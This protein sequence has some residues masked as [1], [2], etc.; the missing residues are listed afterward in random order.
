[1]TRNQTIAVR[2]GLVL[3]SLLLVLMLGLLVLTRT[4]WGREQVRGVVVSQLGNALD[5][6]VE[7][8]RLEGNLLVRWR[9]VDVTIT[10]PEGRPFISA[11]TVSTRFS[12]RGLLRRRIILR[13]PRV[14]R[15]LVVLDHPPGEK[16]NY[17]RILP[18]PEPDPT[19]PGWG[20]WIRL[21]DLVIIDSRVMVRSEWE[22]DPELSPAERERKIAEALSAES[23]ANIQRVPGGFQNIMDFR[24]VSARLS[25]V[26]LADPDADR[27]EFHVAAL[28]AVAQPF[29]PPVA[30]VRGLE[31]TF[32]L[33]ADSLWFEDVRA[34]LPDSRLIAS[35]VY[36]LETAALHLRMTGEPL[37]FNDMR[38]LYPRLPEEGGGPMRLAIQ[39]RQAATRIYAEDM[40]VRVGGGELAGDLR[41]VVGD[42]LRILPTDL[43]FQDLD[44]RPVDRMIPGVEFP[45]HGVLDGRLALR[46]VPAAMQVDGDVTL[47]HAPTGRSRVVAEG[48]VA[49][50][51]E[52]RFSNLS[53][54][55]SPL[56]TD[57]VR[58]EV[59][60]LPPGAALTGRAVLDGTFDGPLRLDADLALEDPAT[61]RSRV[62]ARGT[63][64]PEPGGVRFT[65]FDM[66]LRPLQAELVRPELPELPAGSTVTGRLR[67]D[68]ATYSI[69]NLQG[70]LA[71]SDPATGESRVAVA[72]GLDLREDLRF[73]ALDLTFQPLRA[74]LLRE[75]I[76]Q[77]PTGS[78][79]TGRLRLDGDPTGLLDLDGDLA[80]LDPATG[81]SRVALA[82]GLDLRDGLRLRG[83]DLTFQPLLTDLVREELP[84]LPPD[85]TV[86]G[87]L[88]LDGA[89]G[90]F[91]HVAGD[92]TLR[93][94]A[95]GTSRVAGAGGVDMAGPLTFHGLDLRF[96]PLQMALVRR[97]KPDLP[98]GGTLTGRAQLDGRPDA[99]LAVSGDLVH[100]EPGEV[101]RVAGHVE[102][103]PGGWASVDVQLMPL[104]LVVAGR[105][106]PDAGLRGAVRGNL[107]A[108]GDLGDLSL[109]AD[110]TVDDGG[111]IVAEGHLD[112]EADQPAYDL[113]TRVRGFDLAAVTTRAPATTDLTGD[114]VARGR[115]LDPATMRAELRA[116]LVGSAVEDLAAD[117]IHLRMEIVEGLA[118]VDSSI[119]HI[120][121]AVA[122]A[123]GEFG[124]V[125]WRDGELRYRVDLADLHAVAPVFPAADTGVVVPRAPVRRA[126]LAEARA[127]A[128]RAERRRLVEAI[129]TGRTPPPEAVPEPL[130]FDTLALAGIPRDTVSGSVE[131]E[132]V[133]R[134][135]VEVFDLV[136][137]AEVED[138]VLDG[139]YVGW[140][141]AEYA[142]IQRGVP[143]PTLELDAVAERLLVEGF[144][145]D[146][147]LAY[148]RHRGDR[149]GAGRA[150]LAAWQNDDTDYRADAEYTLALDR[151]EVRLHDLALRFDTI[152]WRTTQPG[153]VRWSGDGVEVESLELASDAGG[154]V[155]VDGRLP[156]DGEAELRVALHEV[157]LAH[158][159]LLLQD[160]RELAGR[161]SLDAEVTGT[162]RSPIFEGVGN[163]VGAKRNGQ[164]FPDA[165]LSFSYQSRELTFGAEFFEEE[166]RSFATA[167][168]V[169]PIDLA[170]VDPASPRLLDR[171]LAVDVRAD[172]LPLD[173]LGALT[174]EVSDTRGVVAGEFSIRGTWTDPVLEGAASVEE[175][176]FRVVGTGVG[177]RDVSGS[178]R[179][180]GSELVVDSLVA[181]SGG[182]VRLTGSLD[183]STLTEP[184]FDLQ[185][186]AENA[187]AMRTDDIQLRV[188]ADLEVTGPFD[189]VLVAGQARTR[190]SVIYIP[191]TRDKALVTLDDPELLDTLE[192]RLLAAAEELIET[193]SPLLGNLEVE[194]DLHIEPDTWV[195]S[196]DYNVEIYTPP[197]LPPLRV[198]LDQSL[199]RLTLEGTVNS[200]RGEYSFMG[201]RFRVTRGSATFVG[202]ADP[203][204]L[205]QVAAEHEVQLPGREAFSI[206]VVIGG[207]AL[208][209]TLTVESDARPPIAE[210]D[211]LTYIALGRAAGSVLQQQGSALSGR[212]TQSGDLV[213]N[214][215]GL[216][217]M[218]M[219]ALAAN[220][221]LDQFESEM[222]RELGLDVLHIAPADLPAELFSGRFTDLFRGTEVEAGRY[223]GPRLF[224]AVRTRLTTEARPGA[225]VEYTTPAGYRWTTS[226]DSRFLPPRPTLREVDPERVSVFGAF[227]FREWR[228]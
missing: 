175:A 99:R 18:D 127:A 29:R 16:W 164:E 149:Q 169:L 57:L 125:A 148:I 121:S 200:D 224:A 33:S 92:L 158:V 105:F 31:G 81:E 197:D 192:G 203:D 213:G 211:I 151:G 134:G 93:D 198:Q 185:V 216:A 188:D 13:D 70:D 181:H 32:L 162:A 119:V 14:V 54:T 73:R 27:T 167:E 2:V 205:L 220:T 193:P 163:V 36:D 114:I 143:T 177:Y 126:A 112:L 47:H 59:P 201:R 4:D 20:D 219:T 76:P 139:N 65:A 106:V 101:S 161:V 196:T 30:D 221:L 102:V 3:S 87:E 184:A 67:L 165:R 64:D 144:A 90:A 50:G 49:M 26:L 97:F 132:G 209:P 83:L 42:T 222:A 82:G 12:I 189:R 100:R 45:V 60:R 170:I 40:D 43:R 61:G 141:E 104:S 115:G 91:L 1:M 172:S 145:L 5:G 179:L 150:V 118:R 17:A 28:R 89:P 130:S 123:D 41:L 75:A 79:V 166:G 78:L 116:D 128:E 34:R 186:T 95:T 160:E 223:I 19:R 225:T 58:G 168:G 226:L 37:A 135:N 214:V 218:Q 212:G 23:R 88:T 140:G 51:D 10:D 68:G 204:P 15:A 129:A 74:E 199:G 191:E 80:V 39:R 195:R 56:R 84:E 53:L 108:Q 6:Q 152:N 136:G 210:T 98:L 69:L 9:F 86:T 111:A 142:W 55:F 113:V 44:T 120:G 63:M 103:V 174:A 156:V 107:W 85:A 183:L 153:V 178:L 110:L 228:F 11:D 25:E 202:R 190:G 22:P 77:L 208:S 154:R 131:A 180:T 46:G 187:W 155:F 171:P 206:R 138:L 8:G 147:A 215:A 133:L 122:W 227:L 62:L 71:I 96:D 173:G 21:N 117:Q 146:S 52:V 66:E 94:P 217:T 157:E 7:I 48:G 182:P 194:V 124:L 109:R 207:T 72:G 176:A 35:G 159:G 137:T 38:W 24:R